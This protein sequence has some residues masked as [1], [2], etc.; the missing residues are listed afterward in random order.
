[1]NKIRDGEKWEKNHRIWFSSIWTPLNKICIQIH[2]F[3]Q[4]LA[5]NILFLGF[6]FNFFCITFDWALIH[7]TRSKLWDNSLNYYSGCRTSDFTLINFPIYIYAVLFLKKKML[8]II[9]CFGYGTN[10]KLHGLPQLLVEMLDQLNNQR[11][12]TWNFKALAPV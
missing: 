6:V 7:I 11:A 2:L 8:S 4:K 10:K 3:L 12:Q 1:M 5:K 9:I